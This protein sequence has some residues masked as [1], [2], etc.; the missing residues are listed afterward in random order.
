MEATADGQC[1]ILMFD[2]ATFYFSLKRD[3]Q[4]TKPLQCQDISTIAKLNISSLF[5][6]NLDTLNLHLVYI[7]STRYAY[8]IIKKKDRGGDNYTVKEDVCHYLRKT[9]CNLFDV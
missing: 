5:A 7:V 1:P 2:D 6:E 4:F 8:L 9:S 3:V